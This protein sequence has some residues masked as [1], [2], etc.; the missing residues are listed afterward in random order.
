MGNEL[1]SVLS[2]RVRTTFRVIADDHDFDSPLAEGRERPVAGLREPPRAVAVIDMGTTSLRM[3]VAEIDPAGGVRTLETL[4]QAVT[5]GKDTFTKGSIQRDTIEACVQALR[6]YRRVLDEYRIVDPHA[7]RVVATS[8]V[9]EAQNRLAFLDRIFSATGFQVEPIDETE[10]NR[11]TYVGV[12]PQLGRDPELAHKPT[13]VAEIGGGSTEILLLREGQVLLSTG[14]RLGS[15]RIR[16]QLDAL[17]TPA[18]KRRALMFEQI[19][20]TVAQIAETVREQTPAGETVE[21]LALGGDV[22][23]AASQL[24]P[25]WES[26]EIAGIPLDAFDEFTERMI[27]F[28]EDELVRRFHLTFP[29]AE[30]L[31]PA[32]LAY[33]QLARDFELDRL[34]V[35]NVN[36]RDGL[37]Q[38]MAGEGGWSEDLGRQIVRAAIELGRR[39]QFDEPHARRV[40]AL[41]TRLFQELEP[42]HQLSSRLE[43]LLHTAALLHELGMFVNVNSHHKHS[44]YLI[45]NSDLFGLGPREMQLVALIARYHRRASPKPNHPG[46]ATLDREQR[47]AVSKLAAILRVADALE[48][49]HTGRITDFELVREKDRFV[50]IVP[51]VD[52]LSLEQL[53]LRQKGSLF[54]DV[55]GRRV[56]LRPKTS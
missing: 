26:N 29:D 44:Y 17:R 42:E 51:N 46:Y 48:C 27:R 7:V 5:L 31:G 53:A 10:V 41:A 40:A 23:Y 47:I 20:R 30:T 14:Y 6:N 19:E 33:R 4:S 49:S 24:L 11:I 56:L 36:L 38:D 55:F 3:A 28:D 16:E 54:E 43:T 21:L 35:S 50:L 32:L 52:D 22:R 34:F 1:E 2:T 12:Q 18:G 39:Y 37:L 8:A 25:G 45:G 13:V 9:R 15:L